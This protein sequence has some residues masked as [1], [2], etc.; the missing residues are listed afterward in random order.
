MLNKC[1]YGMSYKCN[2]GM[3]YVFEKY[4]TRMKDYEKF[5]KEYVK[6]QQDPYLFFVEVLEEVV[7]E[8]QKAFLDAIKDNHLLIGNVPRGIG[9][10]FF[11]CNIALWFYTCFDGARIILIAPPPEANINLLYSNFET[12]IS[13]HKDLFIHSNTGLT[14]KVQNTAESFSSIDFRRIPTTASFYELKAMFS[15]IRAKNLMFLVDDADAIPE[16]VLNTIEIYHYDFVKIQ[17][18][19]NDINKNNH[20]KKKEKNNTTIKFSPFNHLNVITGEDII[21]GCITQDRVIENIN[22]YSRETI[23]GEKPDLVLPDYIAKKMELENKE[24]III[25]NRINFTL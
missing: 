17:Y 19:Y 1:N 24:R 5:K 18:F 14:K 12:L 6:Y 21:P 15:G 10:S 23:N 4:N 25:D 16:V 13:K 20:I 2:C 22:N 8:D 3:S 11:M 7:N 9:T